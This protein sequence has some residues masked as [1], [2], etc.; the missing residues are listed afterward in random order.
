MDNTFTSYPIAD[1]SYISFVKRT[2]HQQVMMRKFSSQQKGEI[3]IIVAEITSNLVKHAGGGE[4]LCRAFDDGDDA[5]FE[6]LGLDRGPGIADVARMMKDGVSTKDTL[7]QG[8][9]AIQ[10]LSDAS[11]VYSLPG[12]GTIVYARVQTKKEIVE[13]KKELDL[14][15][16]SLCIPKLRE[17]VC[18][19]GY[20]VKRSASGF[21]VFFGDGLGHGEHAKAAVD[22]A[23]EYFMT[24]ES[25][26]PTEILRGMHERIRKTRG[27]V[28]MIAQVDI[29]NKRWSICGIGNILGRL[30]QGIAYKNYMSYN[31]TVGLNIPTTIKASEYALEKNQY[32]IMCSDGIRTRWDLNKYAS[33]QRLDPFVLAASIYKDHNRGND[34]ASVLIAKIV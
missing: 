23:G 2:I 5:V 16:K 29:K 20:R 18:G 30:Y 22:T 15:V 4:L 33:V 27:L 11:H 26:D 31:G 7:G 3:D 17:L 32:L 19:D 8:L 1:R 13:R 14:E 28:G 12:W 24:C 21:V 25:E 6:V 9:G 10:R 34:D